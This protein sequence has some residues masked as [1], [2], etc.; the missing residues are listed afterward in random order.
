MR[1]RKLWELCGYPVH[2]VISIATK[3][4][5]ES[6]GFVFRNIIVFLN[7]C[8]YKKEIEVSSYIAAY[9]KR[10][11]LNTRLKVWA[12]EYLMM[13]KKRSFNTISKSQGADRFSCLS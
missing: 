1:K 2:F 3:Y 4:N 10:T 11:K 7:L 5:G 6:L 8:H 13:S 9:N 12:Y